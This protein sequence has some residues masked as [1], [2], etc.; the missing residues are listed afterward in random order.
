MEEYRISLG[1]SNMTLK[2]EPYKVT[3]EDLFKRLTKTFRTE[4]TLEEYK[5]MTK[6]EQGKIKACKGGS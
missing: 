6:D 2:W 1:K 4:E 5:A 3:F